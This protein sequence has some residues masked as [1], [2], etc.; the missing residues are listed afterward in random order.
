M[1]LLLL[2]FAAVFPNNLITLTISN[3]AN[4]QNYTH[5]RTYIYL[6]FFFGPRWNVSA[7]QVVDGGVSSPVLEHC[8]LLLKLL[9]TITQ[10]TEGQVDAL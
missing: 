7:L 4:T 1:W 9:L 8:P 2:Q 5:C 6:F 3:F 10:F